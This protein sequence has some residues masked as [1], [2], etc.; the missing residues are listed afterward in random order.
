[1]IEETG[2]ETVLPRPRPPPRS[3][4]RRI[5][6]PRDDGSR[7]RLGEAMKTFE[8]KIDPLTGEEYYEVY[9]RGQQ[10]LAEK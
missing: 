4:E 6:R 7:T 5:L 9:L 2:R 10:L 8:F 3:A 1:M